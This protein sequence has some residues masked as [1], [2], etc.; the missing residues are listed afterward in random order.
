MATTVDKGDATSFLQYDPA[1][2]VLNHVLEPE[3]LIQLNQF[4]SKLT[5]Y[6]QLA[7]RGLKAQGKLETVAKPKGEPARQP[8]VLTTESRELSAKG[9]TAEVSNSNNSNKNHDRQADNSGNKE[10]ATGAENRPSK[11][12]SMEEL[13][14]EEISTVKTTPAPNP[15]PV[16][17]P[18]GA[19]NLS[20]T[21]D[22]SNSHAQTV[23]PGAHP[24]S[25]VSPAAFATPV[26][27]KTSDQSLV[28]L[29]NKVASP[30]LTSNIENP[31]PAEESLNEDTNQ[32]PDPP[33]ELRDS[34]VSPVLSN[35]NESHTPTETPVTE[36]IRTLA[37]RS[38][39]ECHNEV[40]AS[41]VNSAH[42]TPATIQ[43]LSQEHL[44]NFHRH[45]EMQKDLS[46]L[47]EYHRLLL[48][49]VELFRASESYIGKPKRGRGADVVLQQ[50]GLRCRHCIHAENQQSLAYSFPGKVA[51]MPSTF[52]NIATLHIHFCKMIPRKARS[53]IVKAKAKYNAPGGGRGNKRGGLTPFLNEMFKIL[54]VKDTA[55]GLKLQSDLKKRRS[56]SNASASELSEQS[57]KGSQSS[58]LEDKEPA[59]KRQCLAPLTEPAEDGKAAASAATSQQEEESGSS[60]SN[61][62]PQLQDAPSN[63]NS[64]QL[65]QPSNSQQ[66]YRPN[67][68]KKPPPLEDPKQLSK[69][70]SNSNSQKENNSND[71][72]RKAFQ[73][74]KEK[75]IQRHTERLKALGLSE[76]P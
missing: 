48:D 18:V 67:N 56:R 57:G 59:R 69:S 75:N 29:P 15:A 4:A 73:E 50:V 31:T 64:Q 17:P 10:F 52:R 38:T 34:V 65:F 63:S 54:G 7:N 14:D 28:E 36:S 23:T 51:V 47:S 11:D 60:E 9:E 68:L 72:R 32:K 74:L 27:N 70:I 35:N 71:P 1:A 5:H 2:L 55:K 66:L 33:E 45:P 41:P 13:S 49:H 24:P 12:A 16:A 58:S 39:E 40:A 30:V 37:Q 42:P 21:K 61:K 46:E 44:S 26:T 25:L 43:T 8:A 19:T 20:A 76:T 22:Y 62:P 3:I 53:A 6:L